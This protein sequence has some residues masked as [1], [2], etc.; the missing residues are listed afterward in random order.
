MTDANFDRGFIALIGRSVCAG[1]GW[2]NVN[3][4]LRAFAENKIGETPDLFETRVVGGQMQV[5]LSD[6]GLTVAKWM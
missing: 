5:R 2:R 6:E 1:E 4:K 3:E